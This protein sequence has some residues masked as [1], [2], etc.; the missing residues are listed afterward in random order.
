MPEVLALLQDM[1]RH[2]PTVR[3]SAPE[4]HSRMLTAQRTVAPEAKAMEL[5]MSLLDKYDAVPR[6]KLVYVYSHSPY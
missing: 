3:L 4:A 1:T 2:P 5:P 6:R